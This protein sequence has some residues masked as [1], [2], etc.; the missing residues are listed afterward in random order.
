M[1]LTVPMGGLVHANLFECTGE[2]LIVHKDIVISD[3]ILIGTDNIPLDVEAGSSSFDDF[4][5]LDVSVEGTCT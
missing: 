5:V 2:G 3:L 4:K 1:D